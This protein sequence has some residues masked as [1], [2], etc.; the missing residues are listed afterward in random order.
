MRSGVLVW[1]Q[2]ANEVIFITLE[3]VAQTEGDFAGPDPAPLVVLDTGT[4]V[5][6][7]RVR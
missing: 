1:L 4:G 2:V 5:W 6:Q 7:F 3:P